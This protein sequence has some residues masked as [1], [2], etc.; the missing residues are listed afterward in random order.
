M[1]S[2]LPTSGADAA[3]SAARFYTM[4]LRRD[5]LLG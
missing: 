3:E 4:S 5:W 1:S 2:G